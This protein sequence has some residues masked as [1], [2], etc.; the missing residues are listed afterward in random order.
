MNLF[1]IRLKASCDVIAAFILLIVLFPFMLSISVLILCDLG[2]PVLYR[3]SR[4]GLHGRPFLLIKFRSMV[5]AKDSSGVLLPDCQRL[6]RFGRFLRMTSI[7]E[8]PELVNILRGEM[9]FVGPRP[10]LIQYLPLY[11]AEQARRH[12]VKPGLT[13]WAQINGRNTLSWEEKFQL[14]VRYV[15]NQSFWLDLRILLITLLKVI[16]REGIS[17]V[18][19]ATTT[20]FRGSDSAPLAR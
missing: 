16:S 7:D 20:P 1:F 14:D 18:G 8:L 19:E 11:S 10:L 3:Q 13:G 17:S 5:H 9:S 2:S 15:D 4:L 12:D 6:T